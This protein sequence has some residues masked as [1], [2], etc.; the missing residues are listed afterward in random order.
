MAAAA[1]GI[2]PSENNTQ[3]QKVGKPFPEV[4]S[5]LCLVLGPDLLGLELSELM[6]MQAHSFHSYT[7][8]G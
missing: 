1:P 8:S 4:L 3:K 7:L 6:D 5:R 2:L